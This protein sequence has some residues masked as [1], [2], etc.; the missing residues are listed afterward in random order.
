MGVVALALAAGVDTGCGS[1]SKAPSSTVNAATTAST[2]TASAPPTASQSGAASPPPPAARTV[3]TSR[4]LATCLEQAGYQVQA[5]ETKVARAINSPA[6]V[7]INS[8]IF[9]EIHADSTRKALEHTGEEPHMTVLG[10]TTNPGEATIAV[11]IGA[12]GAQE[13]AAEAQAAAEKPPG[14]GSAVVPAREGVKASSRD[15]V[16]WV[17]WTNAP[18]ISKR[19]ERCLP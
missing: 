6:A 9:S 11:Y 10:S 16:A 1:S 5:T 15:N 19:I 17:A 14:P 12:T 3:V 7:R 4:T 18:M 13:A 8:D 2:P